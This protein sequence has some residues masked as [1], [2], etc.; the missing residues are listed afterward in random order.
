MLSLSMHL[1]RF[2]APIELLLRQRCF[3]KLSMTF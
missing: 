1:Y 2:V 3:G